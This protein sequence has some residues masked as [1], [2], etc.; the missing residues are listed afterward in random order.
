MRTFLSAALLGIACMSGTALAAGP[1]PHVPVNTCT[2]TFP[3]YWQDIDP[4]FA[5]MWQGQVL[6]NAPTGAYSGAIFRLSD[7]YPRQPADDKASQPWRAAK[8]DA[9]FNP[10]TGQGQKAKLAQEYAWL[11]YNYALAGNIDKQGPDRFRCVQE[12][13]APLV[14]HPVSDIRRAHWPGIHPWLDA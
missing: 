4:K 1:N 12:P 5:D 8:F 13:S 14:P 6:S 9:M 2:G 11:V 10:A 7:D 3:S